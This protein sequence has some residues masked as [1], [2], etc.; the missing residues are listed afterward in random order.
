M[1]VRKITS[2]DIRKALTKLQAEY[3]A[4]GAHVAAAA[5]ETSAEL[6]DDEMCG[7]L[8]EIILEGKNQ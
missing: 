2:K 1:Q 6:L 3:K 5:V 7:R 8:G 4:D